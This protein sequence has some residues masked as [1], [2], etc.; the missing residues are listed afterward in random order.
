MSQTL[1]RLTS[2]NYRI[3][4]VSSRS[5]QEMTVCG[6]S[7]GHD[8][9]RR[10]SGAIGSKEATPRPARAPLGPTVDIQQPNPVQP[11]PRPPPSPALAEACRS[12][13]VPDE[14]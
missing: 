3:S 12:Y 8:H 2:D 4:E 5:G 9:G 13:G 7:E 11:D 6:G 14:D 1:D 10:L